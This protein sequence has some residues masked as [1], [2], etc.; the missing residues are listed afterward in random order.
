MT[1]KTNILT[2]KLV[3]FGIP[4]RFDVTELENDKSERDFFF[5]NFVIFTYLNFSKKKLGKVIIDL[6]V[7]V[8]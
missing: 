8:S 6:V 5:S 2:W 1:W 4:L 7:I 3:K